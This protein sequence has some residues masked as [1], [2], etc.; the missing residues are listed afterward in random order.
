M[1]KKTKQKPAGG[2]AEPQETNE[3]EGLF[4]GEVGLGKTSD[5]LEAAFDAVEKMAQK[6]TH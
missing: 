6:T 5:A 4:I 3:L 2:F 1:T